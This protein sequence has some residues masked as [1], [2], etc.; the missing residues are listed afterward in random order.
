MVVNRR[1][2]AAK[3]RGSITHGAGSRKKRRGAGSRGGRGNAGTG[4]RAGHMKAGM[5]DRVLGS[6]GFL[7]RGAAQ[8]VRI[9]NL[10]YFTASRLDQLVK[11]NKVT[12]EGSF[13][14]IDL[15]KLDC[16][17]LL[18]LGETKQKLKIIQGQVSK[19]AEEKIKEVGGEVVVLTAGSMKS[20]D[21]QELKK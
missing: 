16:D 8:P 21:K 9:L 19:K 2:K 17:K 18:S 10:N 3:Y 5:K 7:P 14:I 11:Q 12:K 13:F 6:H 15:L 20:R 4:K 1:K